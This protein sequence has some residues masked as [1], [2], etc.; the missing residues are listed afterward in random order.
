MRVGHVQQQSVLI[1]VKDAVLPGFLSLPAKTGG[2]VIFAHGSGSGRLSPRN[3]FVAQILRAEGFGTF[4]FD[5][6][7][8]EEDEIYENRFNIHLL[9]SRLKEATDWVA[10]QSCCR[11][12]KIGY[13]G[14]STGAAAAIEAAAMLGSKIGAIVSRGGRPDLAYE[15][16][17]RVESP[18]LLVVGKKDK[19]II[20]LNKQAFDEIQSEKKMVL[21]PQAT[22]LFSEPGAL[23]QVAI[24]AAC[25]F[26]NYLLGMKCGYDLI[27]VEKRRWKSV[28]FAIMGDI[29]LNRTT[30][31]RLKDRPPVYLWGDILP[32]IGEADVRIC[33]LVSANQEDLVILKVAG[34]H[35]ITVNADLPVSLIEALG[36]AGICFAQAKQDNDRI[37][38]KIRE[39]RIGLVNYS[40]HTSYEDIIKLIKDIKTCS[41]IVIAFI[42]QNINHSQ[43]RE[44]AHGLID[45]GADIVVVHLSSGV[46]GLEVYRN[47]P[48]IYGMGNIIS[49]EANKHGMKKNESF[50]III[51]WA[52]NQLQKI[53]LHP[54]VIRNMQAE[55]PPSNRSAAMAREMTLLSEKL[56]TRLVWNAD[57]QYLELKYNKEGEE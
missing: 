21:I 12:L 53:F 25:W 50:I 56:G 7:T 32:V 13:F 15:S 46:K 18:S 39:K 43:Q 16:L 34:I 48:I 14:A 5:L 55:L 9:A 4:L 28:E 54:V 8:E 11:N 1:P 22:H 2:L 6:L 49:G 35:A 24:L 42:D 41:D 26:K 17:E 38:F 23:R 36:D 57:N 3:N 19:E 44:Q 51:Q 30:R 47:H 45:N 27:P 37:I 31:T 52:V 33:N 29:V 20:S 10:N 40:F